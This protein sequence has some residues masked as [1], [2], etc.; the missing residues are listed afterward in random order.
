MDTVSAWN[1]NLLSRKFKKYFGR[2]LRLLF[3]LI[4]VALL[5]R[6]EIVLIFMRMSTSKSV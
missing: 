1:A 3:V 4:F 2:A 5:L 6:N